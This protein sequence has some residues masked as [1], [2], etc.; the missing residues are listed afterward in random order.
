MASSLPVV[1]AIEELKEANTDNRQRLQK[2]LRAGLLN[3]V[4][5]VDSLRAV[6]EAGNDAQKQFFAD[7]KQAAM[8]AEQRALEAQVEAQNA[9]KGNDDKGPTGGF[10]KFAKGIGK[11]GLLGGIAALGIGAIAA[12]FGA[13]EGFD[14]G[15]V[16]EN[17][18]NLLSI[19]DAF[20]GSMLAFF[21]DGGIF[22]LA[23]GGIGLGLAAFGI[24]QS[25]AGL[26][27]WV[28]NDN[29]SLMIKNNVL[30][31]ISIKDALGGN[32]SMLADATV[33]TAA[34]GG[35]GL[36]L[37]AFGIGQ[38][39]VALGQ[40]VTDDK[41]A[42]KVKTNVV[43]L[44][45]IKD[46]L[47][48]NIKML[49]DGFAFTLAMAGVGTGLAFF[50]IGSSIAG[51][52]NA[53]SNF[54]GGEEWGKAIKANVVHLL[55][56]KDELGGNWEM[57]KASGAFGLSML[58]V[59]GGLAAF[60]VGSS[61]AGITSALT[62][63]TGGTAWAQGIKDNV[64]ILLSIKD[65]L[66]GNWEMLKDSG[67]FGL[68]MTGIG[69]GLAV[70]GVG[71]AS[72]GVG[73]GLAK[74]S[75]GELWA[76]N[77]KDNVKILMSIKDDLGGSASFIGNSAV[78]LMSMTGIGAGLAAFG[79]G[80]TVANV[81]EGIAKFTSGENWSQ[82]IK[83]HVTTLMSITDDVDGDSDSSKAGKFALGM[84]KI[85][86][87]L[88]AFGAGNFVQSLATAGASILDFFFGG[89][90]PFEQVRQIAN[91]ADKLEKGAA[92][93]DS[94]SGS[95]DKLA[96]LKFDGARLRM[97]ELADDLMNS[98]PAL[99]IAVN[100]GVVGEGWITSGT[101]IKGLAS[102]DIMYEEAARNIRM[103]R[104]A[105]A[106]ME[107]AGLSGAS[108]MSR[109][110]EIAGGA[111]GGTTIAAP[112]IAPTVVGGTTSVNASTTAYAAPS[113]TRSASS[114]RNIPRAGS[115]AAWDF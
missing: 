63:F 73:M 40:W 74:F 46:E 55:S 33:F 35:I 113:V 20:D 99:E 45:S 92:A 1:N 34:M 7:Q 19:K 27:Q 71:A 25:I 93:L 78:F 50:G 26:G 59:A 105:L 68:A 28:T 18:L 36:G 61:I 66:G 44:L 95:L 51:I 60:G 21:A 110:S 108:A 85:A 53:L 43:E 15:K 3:V 101:Q 84:A 57:L 29:W 114:G 67:A 65:E 14:G 96:K 94:I 106:P 91:D 77:V 10:A 17:V 76:Q 90:S 62:N 115:R 89:D 104:E 48:G 47:G 58:G 23:M 24:G 86:S 41:W 13:M 72:T 30:E 56:I 6:F 52:G 39:L 12:L 42:T 5:S 22:M 75:G 83:D 54:G 69:Y 98:V 81:S 31:L 4:K 37:A 49:F 38:S 88:T 11:A 32:L 2:S 100:G 112:V 82:T 87:G 97:K 8:E 109:S 16:K 80:S 107:V 70:F 64:V 111:S 103:I 79:F 102:P 9:G